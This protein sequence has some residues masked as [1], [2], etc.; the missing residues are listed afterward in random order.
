MDT[1]VK[2]RYD[3]REVKIFYSA[4]DLAQLVQDNIDQR[5]YQ[6]QQALA[7]ARKTKE[8][9]K[10]EL[11]WEK[12]QELVA[13]K[14]K[15]RLSPFYFNSEKEL[16][17]YNNFKLKHQNCWTQTKISAGHGFYVKPYSTGFSQ[18]VYACCPWCGAEEDISDTE[19]W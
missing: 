12:E 8:E 4:K 10:N 5:E 19:A 11:I 7:A 16:Q 6:R 1:W 15:I 3:N 13:L 18:G 17:R 9:V 14:A 2:E